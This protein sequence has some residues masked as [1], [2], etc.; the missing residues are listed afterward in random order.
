[1]IKNIIPALILI[2]TTSS[3][4]SQQTYETVIVNGVERE[5]YQY[6]PSTYD[7]QTDQLPVV[8]LLHGLGDNA[9]NT[10]TYGM[11]TIAESEKFIV[12]YPQGMPNSQGN[13]AWNN[14]TLVAST[15]EDLAFLSNLIDTVNTEESIDLS[16]VYFSGISM[17]AIMTYTACRYMSD[18]IAAAVCHIGTMSNQELGNYNPA[19]PVPVLHKH[20]T[21]DQTVPYSGTPFPSLSLVQATIDKL[22]SSNGWLGDS[23]VTTIPDNAADGITVDRIVYNCITPLELWRMNN[24]GH[25]LLFQ[26]YNDTSSFAVEWGFLQQFSHS[27]PAPAGIQEEEN[28]SPFFYP[29]PA[30]KV[31]HLV[32]YFDFDQLMIYSVDGKLISTSGIVQETI[33]VSTLSRGTYILKFIDNN[34]NFSTQKVVIE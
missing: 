34:K 17:G 29:N 30:N 21:D 9:L 13:N 19:Y 27:N 3:T 32:N 14:N 10:S 1:M 6:L 8:F 7:P 24:A 12:I 2:I 16:R 18:R 26:P 25:I 23:T 28:V 31:I 20:G 11:N 4:L 5:Y 33:D 22:K 15:A